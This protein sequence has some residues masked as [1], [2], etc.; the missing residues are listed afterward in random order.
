M[1]TQQTPFG[2]SVKFF[3]ELEKRILEGYRMAIPED[4]PPAYRDL[5]A[6]CWDADTKKRPAFADV[7]PVLAKLRETYGGPSSAIDA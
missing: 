7:L 4:A 1:L 5:V 2:D 6:A 3:F